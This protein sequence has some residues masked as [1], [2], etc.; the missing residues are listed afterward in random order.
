MVWLCALFAAALIGSWAW[1]LVKERRMKK[2]VSALQ[3]ALRAFARG[4]GRVPVGLEDDL[5]APLQKDIAG[6][7]EEVVLAAENRREHEGQVARLMADISHQLKTPL[8][9]L[10]LLCEMD[11]EDGS[12]NAGK[13]LLL[14]GRMEE[15]IRSLLRLEKLKA[16]AYDLEFAPCDLARIARNV[17]AQFAA[18]YPGKRF[19]VPEGSAPARGDAAWLREA[20]ANVVKNACEHTGENGRIEIGFWRG[21]GMVWLQIEDDGGGVPGEQLGG[22]FRRF[23]R[24]SDEGKG[25]SGLG[26]AITRSILECHHGGATAE[27]GGRGLRVILYLPAIADSLM[28]H[29]FG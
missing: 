15:L 23:S 20:V 14:V 3:A 9:T 6:L 12:A 4:E 28:D 29:S 2:R 18:L 21:E 17:C 10:R 24:L 11:Q 8:A 26:L 1:F 27:P 5:L 19:S 16:N 22:L 25:G 13:E 7:A